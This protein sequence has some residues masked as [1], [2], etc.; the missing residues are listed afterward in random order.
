M[1]H[2][3]IKMENYFCDGSTFAADANRHKMVWKK[4]AERY[5]ASAEQQCQALFKQIDAL[6]TA[7]DNQYGGKDLEEHGQSA[8]IT[9]AAIQEQVR[10]LDD[11]LHSTAEKGKQRKA[12]SLKKKLEATA[13]RIEK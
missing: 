4:N 11:Q 5:K 13:I 2:E 9:R 10:Q 7:E 8:T 3:Y 6:N 12:A 1:D